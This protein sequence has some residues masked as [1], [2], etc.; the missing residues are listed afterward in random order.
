M[1]YQTEEE[2]VQRIKDLWSS[3]GVPLLTGVVLALAGVFG[4]QGWNNYQEA[5]AANASALYQNML[6]TMLSDQSEE[7]KARSAELA[8]QIRSDYAGTRY[9]DFAG[10]MQARL[11]VE[12]GDLASAEQVLSELVESRTDAV[13]NE[14]ARQRLA[15]VMAA[16]ER[17][18]EGLKLFVEP[19]SGPLL[20]GREEVRGDLFLG[21]GRVDEARA[22]YQAAIDALEDPR[23]RPQLQLKLDDLAEEV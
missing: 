19:V 1:T 18:E 13:L 10:L 23:Q 17:A 2:Q 21:L 7:A 22:A 11:A 6:E 4:W 5:Q 12:S 14:V 20:A 3:H 15:R 8:A 16:Q 9:A